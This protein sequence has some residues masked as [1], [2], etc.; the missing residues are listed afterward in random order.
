MNPTI[1]WDVVYNRLQ[2][3]IAG[4]LPY[5]KDETSYYFAAVKSQ[6]GRWKTPERYYSVLP[7]AYFLFGAIYVCFLQT[8]KNKG[9]IFV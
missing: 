9:F 6:C 5:G 7:Y 1:I 3:N 8:F 4:A 2:R